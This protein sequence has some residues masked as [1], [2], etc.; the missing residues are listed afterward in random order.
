MAR[1]L[2]G[3]L[4]VALEQAVAAPP[5][6]S[7]LADAGARVI[8][9]ERPEGAFA[10]FNDDYVNGESSYFVWNNRSKEPCRVDLNDPDDLALA[11]RCSDAQMCSSRTSPPARLTASAV[12]GSAQ[13]FRGSCSA[14]LAAM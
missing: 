14:T 6:T 7:Q 10:R 5:A 1:A 12:R 9:L 3:T 11:R 13:N 2:E 4:V 8:K